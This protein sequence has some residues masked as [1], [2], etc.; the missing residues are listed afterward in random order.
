M[1]K[2]VFPVSCLLFPVCL[3]FARQNP[4]DLPEFFETHNQLR[5]QL[6]AAI[7]KKDHAAMEA[8]SRKGVAALPED[9]LWHYNLACSLAL[10]GKEPQAFAMLD[11]ALTLG[12]TDAKLLETDED[13]EPLRKRP[14]F[15]RYVERAQNAKPAAE[16]RL[17]GDDLVAEVTAGNTVFDF[18]TGLFRSY[19]VFPERQPDSPACLGLLYDN[20][21]A[22]HSQL[23]TANFPGLARVVYGEEPLARNLH[24]A[25]AQFL[26]NA[27]TIGN[28]SLAMTEGPYWRCVTRMLVTDTRRGAQL[29]TQYNANHVYVYPAHHDYL[30]AKA[31][32]TFSAN[33]PYV[34]T[35]QGSSV[36]DQPFVNALF[37]ALAAFTPEMRDFL[38]RANRVSPTLHMMLRSTQKHL[39]S[40]DD[41]LTGRAHRP[42]LEAANLD[43]DAMVAMARAMTPETVPPLVFVN[44]AGMDP[45]PARLGAD[46]FDH[47]GD[48]LVIQTPALYAMV[49][50]GPAEKRSFTFAAG[51]VPPGVTDKMEYRWVVLQGDPALVEIKHL[52][53][54]NSAATITL[55]HPPILPFPVDP[56][57]AEPLM[58]S[59]VDVGVFVHNG[60]HW[61][62]PA[63]LSFYYLANEER[64]YDVHGRLGKVDYAKAAG[65]YADPVLS[66]PKRWIDVYQYDAAGR[67]IGWERWRG[68]L[69]DAY[70][71]DGFKVLTRDALD[72]PATA[73]VVEY[74][75]RMGTGPNN[76]VE[77]S[78]G[79]TTRDVTYTYAGPGD[80]RGTFKAKE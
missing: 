34:V 50:R 25:G 18:E 6:I 65:N 37:S 79:E 55:T 53:P 23:D 61:S 30:A 27:V 10:Q 66:L 8:V 21:D 1:K 26:Y 63:M 71:A 39:A 44:F 49:M 58:T 9:A 72:R 24:Q 54:N 17:V 33:P 41:Y 20:R 62:P 64:I 43:A 60:V 36:S 14:D 13:L 11:K 75:P 31:G 38:A 67:R 56:G 32:D 77:L 4:F 68:N 7:Q 5:M 80:L 16:A 28:S 51:S 70:T 35:S 73:R 45:P 74:L 76:G 42:V 40:P 48:E 47:R 78:E 59:R 46:F 12:F 19:F 57:A 52:R 29:F 3:A 2:I 15:K 69:M 22:G